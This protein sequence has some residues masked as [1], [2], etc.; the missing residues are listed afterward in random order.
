MQMTGESYSK[1]FLLFSPFFSFSFF[2]SL[3]LWMSW[4]PFKSNWIKWGRMEM[5]K[6]NGEAEGEKEIYI[7][8]LNRK[9]ERIRWKKMGIMWVNGT[10]L[11]RTCE[12]GLLYIYH[13]PLSLSLPFSHLFLSLY[14]FSHL[15]LS[16][17]S[18]HLFLPRTSLTSS[19]ED[20]DNVRTTFVLEP[21]WFFFCLWLCAWG[22]L[23]FLRS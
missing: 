21:S 22:F 8:E 16:L 14:S 18:F 6:E 2:L 4:Y 19:R 13:S 7:E 17:Y 15:S 5:W 11:N 12:R 1:V 3:S 20:L 10:E 9:K 23:S